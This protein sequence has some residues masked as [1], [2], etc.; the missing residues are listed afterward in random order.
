M[1]RVEEQNCGLMMD[2]TEISL[3]PSW[4]KLCKFKIYDSKYS[5]HQLPPDS[6][7]LFFLKASKSTCLLCCKCWNSALHPT[8]SEYFH[9]QR[10]SSSQF[11]WWG[12]E[13]HQSTPFIER[14]TEALRSDTTCLETGPL[15]VSYEQQSKGEEQDESPRGGWGV[16]VE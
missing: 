1:E 5:L 16:V 8:S 9:I 13:R 2:C 6:L 4:W 7:P 11:P 15:L 12:W 10:L 3:L 14:E